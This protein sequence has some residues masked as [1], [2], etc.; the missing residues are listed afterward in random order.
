V[1][2]NLSFTH[3]MVVLVVALIVLGPHKLPDAARTAGAFVREWRRISAGW[4]SEVRDVLGDLAEPFHEV[5]GQGGA[6]NPPG[7]PEAPT[8]GG[9]AVEVPPLAPIQVPP[10]GAVQVPPLGAFQVPPLAPS[11]AET[12]DGPTVTG[13]MTMGPPH[14][15]S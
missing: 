11:A 12:T 5:L 4:Q 10:L 3:I 13:P 14:E 7:E 15:V 9:P 8:L 1:P 6:A 2:L